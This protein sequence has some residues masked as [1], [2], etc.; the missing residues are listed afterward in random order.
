LDSRFA[1]SFMY[2]VARALSEK[3]EATRVLLAA[4]R[5]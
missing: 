4:S 5:A 1:Y 3:L 2:Q